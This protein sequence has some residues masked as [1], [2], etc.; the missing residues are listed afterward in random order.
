MAA[1][2]AQARPVAAA[3]AFPREHDDT[4]SSYKRVCVRQ[5]EREKDCERERQTDI[6][7]GEGFV[8]SD[9]CLML[10]VKE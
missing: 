1:A 9:F 3:A 4:M 7:T 10:T 6:K 2:E 5:R 8:F